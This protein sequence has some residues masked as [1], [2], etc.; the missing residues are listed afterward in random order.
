MKQYRLTTTPSSPKPATKVNL[1]N[2]SYYF[3]QLT[4]CAE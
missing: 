3:L 4:H 2:D 1:H